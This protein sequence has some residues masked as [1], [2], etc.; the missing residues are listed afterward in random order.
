MAWSPSLCVLGTPSLN[1]VG[2][3]P[4][5]VPQ[6]QAKPPPVAPDGILPGLWV[7]VPVTCTP[8]KFSGVR[9]ILLPE[10]VEFGALSFPFSLLSHPLTLPLLPFSPPSFFLSLFSFPFPPQLCAHF[11]QER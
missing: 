2:S 3:I 8:R 6:C 9:L 5:L 7:G 1:G 11:M 10:L 4:V